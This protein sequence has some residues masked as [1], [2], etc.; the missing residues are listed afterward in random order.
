MDFFEYTYTYY[1]K[2]LAEFDSIDSASLPEVERLRLAAEASSLKKFLFDNK[3]EGYEKTFNEFVL[4]LNAVERL[5][6]FIH[7]L[8]GGRDEAKLF[9]LYPRK[10]SM[11]FKKDPNVA[12]RFELQEYVD[13]LQAITRDDLD[14]AF[15][16][17]PQYRPWLEKTDIII[18]EMTAYIQ[19]ILDRR[20]Q[21]NFAGGY[22][23]ALRDT[24]L[25]YL[26]F[27]V[28]KDAGLDCETVPV[29]VGRKFLDQY[30]YCYYDQVIPPIYDVLEANAGRIRLEEF[31][32]AYRKRISRLSTPDFDRARANVKHYLNGVLK[33]SSY[34]VIESGIQGT[35]PLFLGSLDRRV[36]RFL[37][38]TAAP[39]L[40]HLYKPIIFRDN[41]NFLRE[42]ETLVCQDSLFEFD[43]YRDGKVYIREYQD[44]LLKNMA[45][46]EMILLKERMETLANK[47]LS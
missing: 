47:V 26:G 11:A 27:Q 28:L 23:F 44:P 1:T 7:S 33:K 31:V 40:Y 8:I 35:I 13:R 2:R 15:T 29:I 41:Y 10:V 12:V 4:G 20:R 38:Y 46:Y 24:L 17:D 42:M 32:P 30:G 3:E 9:Y 43:H 19:W 39:W 34:I 37:M 21:T 25:P 6:L 5:A 36:E 16:H 22:I 18:N 45:Y 14:L